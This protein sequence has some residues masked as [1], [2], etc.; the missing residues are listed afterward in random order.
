MGSKNV[1]PQD[2]AELQVQMQC[3]GAL[4]CHYFEYRHTGGGRD[5]AFI[6][7]VLVRREDAWFATRRPA[8]ERFATE[9]W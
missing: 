3:A 7:H 9:Y 4:A 8:M 2:F 6:R 1:C 5:P